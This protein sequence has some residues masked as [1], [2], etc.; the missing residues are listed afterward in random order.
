[1][2]LWII[3]NQAQESDLFDLA[4]I[5]KG[6][7][8]ALRPAALPYRASLRA[9]RATRRVARVA[10]GSSSRINGTMAVLA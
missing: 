5:D 2:G 9:R 8:V 1:M 4:K 7:G 10:P 3:P 6:G